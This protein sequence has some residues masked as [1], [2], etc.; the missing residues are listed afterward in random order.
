M[1]NGDIYNKE[2]A[3]LKKDS[4]ET[5]HL[6]IG[7]ALFKELERRGG[8]VVARVTKRMREPKTEA[9]NEDEA[10]AMKRATKKLDIQKA[11]FRIVDLYGRSVLDLRD[12]YYK[13]VMTAFS[14][15]VWKA[16]G[17]PFV[18]VEVNFTNRE[19]SNLPSQVNGDEMKSYLA[20]LKSRTIASMNTT[21]KRA[22]RDVKKLKMEAREIFIDQF[23]ANMRTLMARLRGTLNDLLVRT[24]EVA[25]Q[26][27]TGAQRLFFEPQRA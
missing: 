26:R 1:A 5:A 18:V 7:N 25:V 16:A 14:T 20:G 3:R 19:L 13:E 4:L 10:L 21:I 17:H 9:E 12:R 11:I 2:L 22:A 15:D 23:R 27:F 24:Y 6:R 8:D